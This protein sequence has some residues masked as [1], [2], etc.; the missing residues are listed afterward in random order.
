MTAKIIPFPI[1]RVVNKPAADPK[2]KQA[3]EDIKIKQFVEKLTEELSMDILAVLQENVVDIKSDN[4][5]RDIAM[6]IESIKSLL[7]RDFNKKHK[8]QDI[9]DVITN[10]MMTQTGQKITNINYDKIKKPKKPKV[11]F[12]PDFSLD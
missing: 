8:Y 3:L 10:I 1:K 12:E 4:F 6:V 5:I 7:Y 9:T 2:I 11:E